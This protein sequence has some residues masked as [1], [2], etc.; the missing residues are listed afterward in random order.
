MDPGSLADFTPGGSSTPTR[1][2]DELPSD[3]EWRMTP[4]RG[5]DWSHLAFVIPNGYDFTKITGEKD[6][7]SLSPIRMD[8]EG[9][10][11]EDTP[12]HSEVMISQLQLSS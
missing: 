9:N 7:T 12:D 10:I 3:Y 8:G 5:E 4:P 2:E 1:D 6:S 11:F